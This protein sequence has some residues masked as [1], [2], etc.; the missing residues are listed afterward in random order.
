MLRPMNRDDCVLLPKEGGE[1]QQAVLAMT[2]T[3]NAILG[4][5]FIVRTLLGLLQDTSASFLT[6]WIV[7]TRWNGLQCNAVLSNTYT[8][9][10][11]VTMG[12]QKDG[13]N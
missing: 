3:R 5:I 12:D 1:K 9:K 8:Y 6:P 4:E 13:S 10:Q 7:Q 11:S 2:A